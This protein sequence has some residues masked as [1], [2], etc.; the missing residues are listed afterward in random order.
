[1]EDWSKAYSNTKTSKI[2]NK[3]NIVS[4]IKHCLNCNKQTKTNPTREM[5]I[6]GN[7]LQRIE[8]C[9]N[10]GKNIVVNL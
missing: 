8:T 10:C 6:I 5:Q 1:M 7:Q 9:A 4:Y 2:I 3:Y